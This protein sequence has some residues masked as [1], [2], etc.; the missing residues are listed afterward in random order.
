MEGFCEPF[1]RC[2]YYIQLALLET[3]ILFRDIGLRC[4]TGLSQVLMCLAVW[5]QRGASLM[6][7]AIGSFLN[8]TTIQRGIDWLRFVGLPRRCSCVWAG[9]RCIRASNAPVAPPTN[10]MA[11]EG[12]PC[13]P[14][15]RLAPLCCLVSRLSLLT[16]PL[17]L[18]YQVANRF[19]V[20]HHRRAKALAFRLRASERAENGAPGARAFSPALS[21]ALSLLRWG[22]KA[23]PP[24]SSR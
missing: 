19:R 1:G 2:S 17:S 16:R 3:K 15:Y 8:S 10:H 20:D 9:G 22:T 24:I 4:R 7:R 21:Y 23:T 11:G 14:L 18:A 12:P 13:P 5:Q 6:G